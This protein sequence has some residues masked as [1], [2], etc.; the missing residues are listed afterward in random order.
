MGVFRFKDLFRHPT[1]DELEVRLLEQA[2][3]QQLEAEQQKEYWTAQ[4][5]FYAT[6][7]DRLQRRIRQRVQET[8]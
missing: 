4:T 6:L 7:I 1:A 8:K 2:R 5:A 3:R